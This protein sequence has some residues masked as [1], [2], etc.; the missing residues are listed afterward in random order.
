MTEYSFD[1]LANYE[2]SVQGYTYAGI[3]SIRD[4]FFDGDF[5]SQANDDVLL[6]I[7]EDEGLPLTTDLI[8]AWELTPAN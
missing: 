8:L 2:L 7:I 3:A 1:L 6:G 4:D 5:G